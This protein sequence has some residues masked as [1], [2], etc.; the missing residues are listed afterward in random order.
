MEQERR[1][2]AAEKIR[3]EKIDKQS[4]WPFGR[5]VHGAPQYAGISRA[6]AGYRGVLPGALRNV[7]GFHLGFCELS[8]VPMG[9]RLLGAFSVPTHEKLLGNVMGCPHRIQ[10]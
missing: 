10:G 6:A 5:G 2:R 8:R 4:Q 9:I 7:A 3:G 1:R